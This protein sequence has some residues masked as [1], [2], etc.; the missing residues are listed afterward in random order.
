MVETKKYD[1]RTERTVTPGEMAQDMH[2]R[3]SNDSPHGQLGQGPDHVPETPKEGDIQ[4]DTQPS[5]R[6]IKWTETPDI[7]LG[8][9][10]QN[11]RRDVW[12]ARTQHTT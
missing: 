6:V 1:P 5:Q 7:P 8:D 10:A 3:H 4:G 9:V 12:S 2:T 11:D